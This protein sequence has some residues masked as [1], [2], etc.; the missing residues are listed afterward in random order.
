MSTRKQLSLLLY[1][2][3][4]GITLV[5]A[6]GAVSVFLI[7]GQILHLA[8]ETSP[9]QVSIAKLQQGFEHMSALFARIDAA[10]TPEELAQIDSEFQS[11][12]LDVES[13]ATSLAR[14]TGGAQESKV[15]EKMTATGKRLRAMAAQRL[16]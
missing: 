3:V 15:V 11:A 1:V 2:L 14:M 10:D 8:Q 16:E 6:A 5:S 4:G 12:T 7:R 13:S 9:V